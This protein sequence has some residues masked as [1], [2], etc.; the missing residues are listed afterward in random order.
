L[1]VAVGLKGIEHEVEQ[2]LPRVE[3]QVLSEHAEMF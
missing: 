2:A 1:A 3:R